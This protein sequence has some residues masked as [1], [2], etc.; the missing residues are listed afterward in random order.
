MSLIRSRSAG[1]AT[2]AQPRCWFSR[3]AVVLAVTE[4]Q[5]VRASA[6]RTKVG[7]EPT[8]PLEG[9]FVPAQ[10]H[11]RFDFS[12]PVATPRRLMRVQSSSPPGMVRRDPRTRRLS[13][14]ETGG[15]FWNCRPGLMPPCLGR[16]RSAAPAGLW[17]VC[18]DAVVCVLPFCR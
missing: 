11:A 9:V 17:M 13:S 4:A 2:P 16:V 8:N 3:R 5:V 1:C 15:S 7:G 12:F 18:L 6:R 10:L 14:Q